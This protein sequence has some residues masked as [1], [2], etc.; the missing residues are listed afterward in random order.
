LEALAKTTYAS[1]L[2]FPDEFFLITKELEKILAVFK[3]PIMRLQTATIPMAGYQIMLVCKISK[4]LSSIRVS[5]C[6]AKNFL[7]VLKHSFSTRFR[8]LL[9][10][11][12]FDENYQSFR[13]AEF[14]DPTAS[15]LRPAS[16]FSEPLAFASDFCMECNERL[17]L[18]LEML[19]EAT[20]RAPKRAR[21]QPD[22]AFA[23]FFDSAAGNWSQ[24]N[25]FDV[26][27]PSTV[28]PALD[29]ELELYVTAAKSICPTVTALGWW[30]AHASDFPLLSRIAK[31]MLGQPIGTC[32]A[33]RR[34]SDAGNIIT[35]LRN[36]LGHKKVAL[37]WTIHANYN[38]P[39]A[40]NSSQLSPLLV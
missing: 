20:E 11:D 1:K 2:I 36:R 18:G 29:A 35:K 30:K 34:C 37:L 17:K 24:D 39:W 12:L 16:E 25:T 38:Q 14:L 13:M 3:E 31:V 23:S 28:K 21:T 19:V 4:L 27:T 32:D 6:A 9:A 33:E 5:T 10:E 8:V 15:R 40:R 7:D 26:E 22:N